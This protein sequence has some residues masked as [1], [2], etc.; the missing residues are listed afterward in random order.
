MVLNTAVFVS[1]GLLPVKA[2]MNKSF[3][4]TGTVHAFQNA[5]SEGS[6]RAANAQAYLNF[7][8]THISESTFSGAAD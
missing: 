5:S 7:L 2:C 1:F 3:C 6:D 4:Q 8:C